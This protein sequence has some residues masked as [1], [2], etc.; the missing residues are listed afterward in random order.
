MF[1]EIILHA[2]VFLVGLIV[3]ALTLFSAISTFV[4]P[5]SARSPLTRLVFRVLR[6]VFDLMLHFAK[7]Y[8]RRDA[9]MAY[10]APIGLMMLLP[11]WYLLISLGY[12]AM[13]WGLGVG[14]FVAAYK[15]SGSSLFTLG[16]A[17]SQG[18]LAICPGFQRGHAWLDHGGFVDR[19]SA[20]HVRSFFTP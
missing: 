8:S 17:A 5:R 7:T 19:L 13:Y 6:W 11:A 9:I 16:F 15:L 1:M 14:S 18:S 20:D 4:L 12:A 10:Y 3:V 2:L